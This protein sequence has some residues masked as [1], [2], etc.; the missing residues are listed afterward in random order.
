M[1][2]PPLPL[3]EEPWR[4]SE[5]FLRAL[6]RAARLHAAQQRKGSDTPYL[7]HLLA[8]AALVWEY[9]GDEDEAIAALLHDA[10]EDVQP[11]EAAR[12][13]V[14]SFGVRVLAIVEGCT[15]SD[16]HP[17]KP[18]RERK[19]AYLEHLR[20]ADASVLLVSGADKLHNARTLVT[21]LR[22]IGAAVW[23]RF[24]AGPQETLWYYRSTVSVMRENP[25]HRPELVDELDRTVRQL[26]AWDARPARV[27]PALAAGVGTFLVLAPALFGVFAAAGADGVPALAAVLAAAVSAGALALVAAIVS[28]LWLVTGARTWAVVGVLA[29]AL[30]LWWTLVVAAPVLG[31]IFQDAVSVVSP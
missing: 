27:R 30:V 15:D 18:W 28:H 31:R 1:P 26:E 6:D 17:K 7:S 5:R 8:T 19:V 4:Y 13:T 14:A 23:D 22:R 2:E 9:G 25:A 3:P 20:E 29:G 11:T 10:I 16:T 21:D 24:N 12:A